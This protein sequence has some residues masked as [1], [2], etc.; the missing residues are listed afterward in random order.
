MAFPAPR[1]VDRYLYSDYGYCLFIMVEMFPATR[2]V[3]G[4]YTW[5]SFLGFICR[6][7]VSGHSRGR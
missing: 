7:G 1:E 4:S 6:D 3:I 5:I 2:E